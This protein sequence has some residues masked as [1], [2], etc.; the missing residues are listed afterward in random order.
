MFYRVVPHP[1]VLLLLPEALLPPPELL[2]L[3]LEPLPLLLLPLPLLMLLLPLAPA[4]ECFQVPNYF[5]T[6]STTILVNRIS[7]IY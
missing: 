4:V 5:T 2:L 1:E 7:L 3:L 6:F